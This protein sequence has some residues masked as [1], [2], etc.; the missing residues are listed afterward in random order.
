[1]YRQLDKNLLNSN[2]F[3]TS[4]HIIVNVGPLT[5]ESGSGVWG[6]PANFHRFSILASLLH[7]RCSTEVNQTLHDVWP[8]PELL[9]YVYILGA[10]SPNGI[11]PC[12]KFTLSPSLAYL[13]LAALLHGTRAVGVHQTLRCGSLM[14]QGS[15]PI[16]HW[17]V[18]LS[19]W[20]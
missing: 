7:Q 5:A 14:R 9:H 4:S 10:F 1:M 15:H 16:Q 6:T 18:E 19:R 20:M 3:S 17:A 11:L 8:S 2:I 13:I 12:A